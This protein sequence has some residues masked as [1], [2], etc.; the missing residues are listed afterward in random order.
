MKVLLIG[1]GGREHALGWKIAQSPLLSTLYT[2]SANPG[3]QALGEPLALGGDAP[4]EIARV[5]D[6]AGVDLV[7][8]G[9]EAPLAAGLADALVDA[10]IPCFGPT[11]AA[12]RLETSKAF[13]KEICAAAGAPTAD[14]GRFDAAG[15][16][17]DH[18]RR[19]SPPYVVKAD[20]LAAGKGVVVA[21]TLQEADAAVDAMLGGAHGEAGRTIVIEEFLEGEE[22]SFFAFCD[23]ERV[24]PLIGA[25]DHKRAFDG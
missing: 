4:D 13:M 17:R 23:G 25:Q 9:P 19:S 24:V 2:V 8:V 12:A 20:G 21:E 15:P 22:A 18:L 14:Y 10:Q 7:V 11:A 16:A 1:G 6:D 3:L 5:A